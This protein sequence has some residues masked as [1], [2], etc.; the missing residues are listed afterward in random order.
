MRLRLGISLRR[1]ARHLGRIVGMAVALGVLGA[2]AGG[3]YGALCAVLL[4]PVKGSAGA[5]LATAL[6]AAEA[7]AI[8]GALTGAFGTLFG[9][10]PE[11]G[12]DQD[13]AGRPVERL[14]PVSSARVWVAP[15][16]PAESLPD[17]RNAAPQP[18]GRRTLIRLLFPERRP[19][20]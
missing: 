7:G 9:G 18:G 15:S 14:R 12:E 6:G 2:A 10:E 5:I 20:V 13:P 17:R 16:R 1:L 11:D 8:A 4:W 19:P 3:L